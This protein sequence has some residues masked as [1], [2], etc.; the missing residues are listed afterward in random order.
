[1]RHKEIEV[2]WG[3]SGNN[4]LPGFLKLA[5]IHSIGK[6]V[7]NSL[8]RDIKTAE[9]QTHDSWHWAGEIC[10]SLLATYTH[11]SRGGGGEGRGAHATHGH[12]G[13]CCIWD[14]GEQLGVV[15]GRLCHINRMWCAL[16]PEGVCDGL[17]WIILWAVRELKPDTQVWIGAV[18]GHLDKEGL[19][20]RGPYL[21]QQSGEG[22]F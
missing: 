7:R 19:F 13:R 12:M 4:F 1:M 20:T 22:E 15:G 8:S 14:H 9:Q 11:S 21:W 5:S 16:V 2:F 17:V 18:S 3:N 10:S 6:R